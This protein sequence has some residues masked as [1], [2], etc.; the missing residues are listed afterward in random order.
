MINRP[1]DFRMTTSGSGGPQT[2]QELSPRTTKDL[3]NNPNTEILQAILA[4]IDDLS[5]RIFRHQ[6][7]IPPINYYSRGRGHFEPP[8][9]VQTM[10]ARHR[11][12]QP[13]I[14]EG[15]AEKG[16]L[17]LNSDLVWT[18]PEGFLQGASATLIE[19]EVFCLGHGYSDGYRGTEF[20]NRA[21]AFGIGTRKAG[22]YGKET[23]EDFE[24]RLVKY[25]QADAAFRE[26]IGSE[27]FA[28]L[29]F[30]IPEAGKGCEPVS[31]K[32]GLTRTETRNASKTIFDCPNCG[33]IAY[34][35]PRRGLLCEDCSPK[36]DD[37]VRMVPRTQK[38]VVARQAALSAPDS[39]VEEASA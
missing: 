3:E 27:H 39:S 29:R 4:I 28:R 33:A 11:R 31:N 13:R 15:D 23:L 34:G 2:D 7:P 37:N 17:H 24:L 8:P 10:A 16:K 18:D 22:T 32:T 9:Q 6:L 12:R 36:R 30:A 38:S 5:L 19:L 26:I 14:A 21:R 20:R 1:P 35:I 25:S